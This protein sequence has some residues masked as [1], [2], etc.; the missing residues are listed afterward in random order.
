MKS[1]ENVAKCERKN[2]Y[3]ANSTGTTAKQ[4]TQL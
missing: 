4:E 1:G 2:Y 3:S